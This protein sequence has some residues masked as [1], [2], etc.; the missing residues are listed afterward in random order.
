[1]NLTKLALDLF[2]V[3]VLAFVIDCG[4]LLAYSLAV[5]G[6][7]P[8]TEVVSKSVFTLMWASTVLGLLAGKYR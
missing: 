3:C 2:A 6:V 4:V 8:F 7:S 1:M 5:H